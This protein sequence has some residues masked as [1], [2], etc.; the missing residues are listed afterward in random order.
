MQKR[1]AIEDSVMNMLDTYAQKFANLGVN[2]NRKQW[3]A[4]TTYRAPHKPLLLLVVMDLCAQ[5]SLPANLTEL[6]PEP[7]ELLMIAEDYAHSGIR[8]LE[9]SLLKHGGQPLWNLISLIQSEYKS[10]E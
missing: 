4:D 5:G 7:G 8:E 6:T 2:K 1:N 3:T 10:A 9:S